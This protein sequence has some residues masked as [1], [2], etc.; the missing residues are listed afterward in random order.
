MEAKNI[1]IDEGHATNLTFT[2]RILKS[3]ET[4]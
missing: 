4:F 2:F 1:I 3:K